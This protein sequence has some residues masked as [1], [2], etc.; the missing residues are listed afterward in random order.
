MTV[1]AWDEEGAARARE[2]RRLRNEWIGWLETFRW[3]YAVDVSFRTEVSAAQVR[4]AVRRWLRGLG[5]HAYG[6]VIPA[7]G[8]GG[9]VH[10]HVLV[11]GVART[12]TVREAMVTTWG[13][14]LIT[15]ASYTPKRGA[16]GGLVRYRI[17][18]QDHD[19]GE[20]MLFGKPLPY[21]PRKRGGRR[22]GGHL[23]GRTQP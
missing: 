8:D 22:R 6:V 10:G 23:R 4:R 2:A 17:M 14:G 15:V 11:G 20:I 16:C 5:R 9:R 13:R 3:A 21:K 19:P 7:V 12:P 1:P 18:H